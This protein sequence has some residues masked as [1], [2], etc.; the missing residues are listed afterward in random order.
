MV[1]MGT[2]GHP[3]GV[4][5]WSIKTQ[6]ARKLRMALEATP[7]A[8]GQ[9][10]PFELRNVKLA[11]DAPAPGLVQAL[12]DTAERSAPIP[13]SPE[14]H[15]RPGW[16]CVQYWEPPHEGCEGGP[17]VVNILRGLRGGRVLVEQPYRGY[18]P[19]ITL[20][21]QDCQEPS[22]FLEVVAT[23]QPSPQKLAAFKKWGIPAYRIT[24]YAPEVI[25][26]EPMPACVLDAPCRAA[27][28][29]EVAKLNKHMERP[30]AFVGLRN[31]PSNAQGY[32]VGEHDPYADLEWQYGE[33][34]TFGLTSTLA[35]FPHI[36]PVTE[37]A[38]PQDLFLI[39]LVMQASL[40]ALSDER[41]VAWQVQRRIAELLSMV[42]PQ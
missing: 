4:P 2:P 32:I 3:E 8:Y 42:N 13:G 12:Q 36:K 11:I 21:G 7:R 39:Y 15:S 22:C 19:D 37:R 38:I 18:Q 5:H 33:P 10:L 23:S 16:A 31:Y 40:V 25:T 6:V 26:G 34:E 9:P 41:P 27:W 14:Y 29:A 1:N 30:N 17:A 20:Y 35:P 28:R 24:A